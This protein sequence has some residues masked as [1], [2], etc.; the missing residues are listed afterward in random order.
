MLGFSIASIA[1]DS[2]LPQIPSGSYVLFWH[3]WLRKSVR[4]GDI[5]KVK[6]SNKGSLVK[7]VHCVDHHGLIWLRCIDCPYITFEE[8]EPVKF[9]QIEGKAI[10]FTS[11]HAT[12]KI[13]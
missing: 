2:M 10:F 11:H 8:I 12:D 13:A 3:P 4:Q 5:V 9:S 6:Q 7:C 1:G